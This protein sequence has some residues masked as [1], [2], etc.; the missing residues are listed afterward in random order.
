MR[1]MIEIES[2][3]RIS[4]DIDPHEGYTE[5]QILDLIQRGRAFFE[6]PVVMEGKINGPRGGGEYGAIG[7]Y[8]MNDWD[9]IE[10]TTKKYKPEK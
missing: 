2:H 3:I 7:T 10:S 6:S 5:D 4:Y 9:V 1:D 8:S